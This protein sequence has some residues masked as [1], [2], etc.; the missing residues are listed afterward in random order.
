MLVSRS[1]K[2]GPVHSAVPVR[3]VVAPATAIAL[4]PADD[5]SSG[6][7]PRNRALALPVQGGTERG[8]HMYYG[9]GGLL[10]VVLLIV[11]LIYL[12]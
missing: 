6:G 2:A 4:R 11:L 9:A 5:N 8:N 3:V 1:G 7:Q 12:L 10:L